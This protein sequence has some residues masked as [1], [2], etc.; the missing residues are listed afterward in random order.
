M[1]APGVERWGEHTAFLPFERLLRAAF[2][3]TLVAPVP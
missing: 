2:G 1:L 3:Q